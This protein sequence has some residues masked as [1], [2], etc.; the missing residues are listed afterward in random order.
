MRKVLD[1]Y[2]YLDQS[3]LWL[4]FAELA[5]QLINTAF[6]TILNLFMLKNGYS[7][8]SIAGFIA[9]RFLVVIPLA[10]PLGLFIK[11]RPMRPLLYAATVGVCFFGFL[12]VWATQN[13]SDILLATSLTFWGASFTFMQVLAI[14]FILRH[15][16]EEHQSEAISL[17][18]ATYSLGMILSGGI[19]FGLSSISSSLF[20][21]QT[22]LYLLIA[23][24]CSGIFFVRQITANERVPSFEGKRTDLNHY[25]WQLIITGLLP[26]FVLAI[27]SG[28]AIQFMN[29]FFYQ[30]FGLDSEHYAL[31]SG[32]SFVLVAISTLSVPFIKQKYGYGIAMIS[33][34]IIAI[35]ALILMSSMAFFTEYTW[36]L[37][38]AIFFFLLRQPL[39][40]MAAPLTTELVMKYVGKKNHEMASAMTA[41]IWSGSWFS[42]ALLFK[43]FRS[44]DISYGWIFMITAALYSIGVVGYYLL[45]QKVKQQ[46]S[47]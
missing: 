12:I 41:S 31:L 39:M 1:R 33:V 25:D 9:Y 27:G 5:V 38:A 7:E 18:Y 37:P 13:H 2:R 45:I 21:E 17:S 4:I 35:L 40:N 10:F 34:Q 29:L 8:T 36:A 28:L 43:M 44:A 42:S 19:I 15:A 11:G 6:L 22:L 16:S 23:A 26:S 24:G 20:S 47:N 14:P 32:I 3:T 30:L 46:T